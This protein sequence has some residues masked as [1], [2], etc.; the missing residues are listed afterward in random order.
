M[1]VA[2]FDEHVCELV[3]GEPVQPRSTRSGNLGGPLR[4]SRRM[5]PPEVEEELARMAANRPSPEQIAAE[6]QR[7]G[8]LPRDS[9]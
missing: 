2:D 9:A 1:E 5:T 3:P 6:A 7:L 4:R 8:L